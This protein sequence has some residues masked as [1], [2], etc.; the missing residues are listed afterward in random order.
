MDCVIV[1]SIYFCET[2]WMCVLQSVDADR[3]GK[4]TADELQRALLNGNWTPFNR[5]TCRLMIGMFDKSGYDFQY[6]I[7]SFKFL[8]LP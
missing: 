7:L 8:E 2:N 5:E 3:S 1:L 4:I 6:Q